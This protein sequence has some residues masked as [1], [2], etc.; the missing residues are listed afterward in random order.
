MTIIGDVDSFIVNRLKLIQVDGTDVPVLPYEPSRDRGHTPYPCFS[1]SRIGFEPDTPRQRFGIEVFKASST[2]RV[3]RLRNGNV[4][5]VPE[6]YEV[7]DYPGV[8]NLRYIIDTESV[9]KEHSD[10]LFVMMKQAFPFGYEPKISGQ[11]ML[12]NFT[13]PINKDELSIPLFKTSWF[14]DVM[15]VHIASLEHYSV[16][17]MSDQLFDSE[18]LDPL[19][20]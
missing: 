13:H 20:Y 8:Y 5:V 10:F 16:G 12:F 7:S 4:R 11:Y 18:L 9:V 3:V 19:L 2:K 6:S 1:V 15:S 14:F 17:T